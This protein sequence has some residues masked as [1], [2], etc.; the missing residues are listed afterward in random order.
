MLCDPCSKSE[1]HMPYRQVRLVSVPKCGHNSEL[2]YAEV[3]VNP[4]VRRHCPSL[5]RLQGSIENLGLHICRPLRSGGTCTG[6]ISMGCP[7]CGHDNPEQSSSCEHCGLRLSERLAGTHDSV[8]EAPTGSISYAPDIFARPGKVIAERWELLEECGRGGM[9]IVFRACDHRLGGKIVA[10]K[11][12]N[13]R[14]TGSRQGIARFMQETQVLGKLRH[15]GCIEVHNVEQSEG[16]HFIVMEW[17]DGEDLCK[18]LQR[19][20]PMELSRAKPLLRQVFDGIGEA[21]KQGVLHRDIKPGNILVAADGNIKIV[22]FGLARSAIDFNLSHSGCSMGTTAYMSPEQRRDAKHVDHRS[23]IFA[24]GKTVYHML[25]GNVPDVVDPEALPEAIRP[26]VMKALKPSPSERWASVEEFWSALAGGPEPSPTSRGGM[27]GRLSIVLALAVVAI[28]GFLIIEPRINPVPPPP[29][30]VVD[31]TDTQTETEL[32]TAIT[33]N[34]ALGT[35]PALQDAETALAMLEQLSPQHPELG[36]LRSD[37]QTAIE[38]LREQIASRTKTIEDGLRLGRGSA[39]EAASSALV[40]LDK[41]IPGDLRLNSLQDSLNLVKAQ[42]EKESSYETAIETNI[43]LGTANSLDVAER[44]CEALDRTNPRNPRLTEF[45][46]AIQ[47]ARDHLSTRSPTQPTSDEPSPPHVP[48]TIPRSDILLL[49]SNEYT[50]E[51]FAS[52]QSH[53]LK[54]VDVATLSDEKVQALIQSA[55]RGMKREIQALATHLNGAAVLTVELKTEAV[56]NDIQGVYSQHAILEGI[57]YDGRTGAQ[58]K[59]FAEEAFKAGP[60]VRAARDA[61]IAAAIEAL[62]NS[63]KTAFPERQREDE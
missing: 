50:K 25:T 1:H 13:E 24:L 36:R 51:I 17:V 28:I 52:L 43:D 10:I 9:G 41:L 46:R 49:A 58:I 2:V 23:D 4:N 8:G 35:A 57:L 59:R 11:I 14:Q 45:K 56:R 18:L 32:V 42:W 16:R 19:E 3:I 22:D 27:L 21:H 38:S 40:V 39:I 7:R 15:P 12:L 53:E 47:E 5:E 62:G 34:M 33:T 37:L 63:V 20:G 6:G 26:V 30:A 61:A 44:E 29:P 54:V 55:T 31:S 60:S 48:P